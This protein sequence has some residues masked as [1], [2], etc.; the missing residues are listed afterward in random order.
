MQFEDGESD[1]ITVDGDR[2][3]ITYPTG[4]TATLEDMG[5]YY[6]LTNSC[7][8]VTEIPYDVMFTLLPLFLSINEANFTAYSGKLSEIKLGK[9]IVDLG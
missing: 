9:E 6:V 7:G 5:N 8:N 1:Y 2:A 4:K 3:I